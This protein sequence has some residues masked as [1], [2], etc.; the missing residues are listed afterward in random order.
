VSRCR[1]WPCHLPAVDCSL[2][3]LL[4]PFPS[5]TEAILTPRPAVRHVRLMFCSLCVGLCHPSLTRDFVIGESVSPYHAH[6]TGNCVRN[7]SISALSPLHCRGRTD[8]FIIL[9]TPP[10]PPHARPYSFLR[11][12]WPDCF[13]SPDSACRCFV[14]W[15]PIP[16]CGFREKARPDSVA[17]VGLL[18]LNGMCQQFVLSM[19]PQTA[20]STHLQTFKI[21]WGI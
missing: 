13:G 5:G 15:S 3:S 4:R 21:F 1:F 6:W 10:P 9:P 16:P 20:A 17:P 12:A 8:R 18:I 2:F 19:L 11:R 14:S 7:W